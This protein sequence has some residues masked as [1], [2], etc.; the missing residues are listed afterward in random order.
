MDTGTAHIIWTIAAILVGYI[1]RWVQE[2]MR[3]NP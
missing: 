1:I 2:K 3:Y